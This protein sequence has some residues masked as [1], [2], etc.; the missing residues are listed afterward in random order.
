MPER[1]VAV[2]TGTSSGI[3]LC[4]AV[5]LASK[6][7]RVVA[8]MRDPGKAAA[9]LAEAADQGVEVTVRALDVTDTDGA[10]RCLDEAEAEFGPIGILVNNGGQGIGGTLEQ[11]SDAALHAELAVHLLGPAALETTDFQWTKQAFEMLAN[12]GLHGEVAP[13]GRIGCGVSFLVELPVL[14]DRCV[15]MTAGQEIGSR[16]RGR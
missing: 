15:S 11:L 7:M 1:T 3:G 10:R 13:A 14:A 9:L 5:G 4:T 16:T 12:G 8:T 6:G 2:V